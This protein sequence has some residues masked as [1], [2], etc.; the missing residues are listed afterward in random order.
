MDEYRVISLLCIDHKIRIFDIENPY[1]HIHF[2]NFSKDVEPA[3]CA[4]MDKS[5]KVVATLTATT[6]TE[7]GEVQQALD[8][9]IARLRKSEWVWS[10]SVE[11][12][13]NKSGTRGGC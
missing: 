10:L 2:Y 9:D 7:S 4:V 5:H 3:V 13:L 8:N 12:A 6:T 11:A 1:R